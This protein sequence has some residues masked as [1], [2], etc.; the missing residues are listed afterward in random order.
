MGAF[1]ADFDMDGASGEVRAKESYCIAKK[2]YI[3]ILESVDK[4]GKTIDCDHIRPK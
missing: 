1:H 4:N 3:D 2:V